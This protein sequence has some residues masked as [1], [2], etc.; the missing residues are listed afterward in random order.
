MSRRKSSKYSLRLQAGINYMRLQN[1]DLFFFVMDV[2][3]RNPEPKI[4]N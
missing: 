4:N 2:K 3:N 1:G